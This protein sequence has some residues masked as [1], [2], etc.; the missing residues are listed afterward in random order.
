MCA[1]NK[2]GVSIKIR[3]GQ[4]PGKL[5][6][7]GEGHSDLGVVALGPFFSPRPSPHQVISSPCTL[8]TFKYGLSLL[9]LN[10]GKCYLVS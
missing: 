1:F 3:L 2:E 5:G 6:Y 7:G 10:V 8:S 9:A 4:I